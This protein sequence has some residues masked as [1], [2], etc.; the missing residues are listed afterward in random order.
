MLS[1]C[2]LSASFCY[3][4][5]FLKV[6]YLKQ[7]NG[8]FVAGS[9]QGRGM[10]CVKRVST[11]QGNSRGTALERHGMCESVLIARACADCLPATGYF[12]R[13]R[14]NKAFFVSHINRA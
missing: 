10:V 2:Q 3:H 13:T 4:A 8:R 11:R 1:T 5:K 6:C 9:W 12:L 14:V 7:E